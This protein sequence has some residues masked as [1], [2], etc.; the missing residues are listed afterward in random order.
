M[1]KKDAM[2]S[3]TIFEAS[4]QSLYNS[5]KKNIQ[6]TMIGALDAIEKELKEE[7][8]TNINLQNKYDEIRQKILDNG[9]R[10]LRL[11]DIELNKYQIEKKVGFVSLNITRG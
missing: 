4:K 9:N 6:T 1:F 7:L 10:Q 11:L 5:C 8:E 2:K 3:S